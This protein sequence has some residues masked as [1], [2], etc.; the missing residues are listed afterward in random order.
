MCSAT[1]VPDPPFSS[2]TRVCNSTISHDPFQPWVLVTTVIMLA[3]LIGSLVIKRRRIWIRLQPSADGTAT[4]VEI[5][6]LARTD[7]AGWGSEFDDIHRELLGLPDPD[8]ID[9]DAEEA[10]PVSVTHP[11]Q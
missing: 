4:V 6:G 3:S 2:K 7:R 10:T 1:L 11:S 8:D 9:E 5:A